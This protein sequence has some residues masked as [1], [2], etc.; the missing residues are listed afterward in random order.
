MSEARKKRDEL[1]GDIARGINPAQAIKEKKAVSEGKY[2]FEN[3][4]KDYI[5][6]FSSR[7]TKGHA[8]L[9]Y[10]RLELNVFP[11]LGKQ[12]I[13]TITAPE[14]LE[15]LRKIEKRGALETAQRVR[16]IC[17]SVFRYAIAT[18]LAERDPA[19][20]LKGALTPPPKRHYA[21]ITEPK[22][23]AKL[24]QDMEK[25]EASYVVYCALQ[26]TPHLFVRPG[27]L[28]H[29]E[30]SEIDFEAKE[31]R[32]PAEKMKMKTTHIVPLSK[33]VFAMLKELHKYTGEGKYLF[34]AITSR[35]RP[36]SENTIN[37]ALRR[38]GYTKDDMT[39]H[40]FRSLASTLLNEQGWNRDA[41]ERQLAHGERNKVRAAYNYAEFMPERR[42]MMQWWS[43]YLDELRSG[44]KTERRGRKRK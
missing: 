3:V 37:V 7:W 20:D 8:E 24:L 25:C 39:A 33:Q 43:D 5:E 15:V 23:V 35:L 16:G 31:W 10:R 34:P 36:M 41:I 13:S 28:R 4:A 29:A 17:S 12:A 38:I 9:V 27:E 6:K 1:R 2:H 21:S 11:F 14:L 26:I 30:W 42:K 44:V 32:I 18:G 40:G 19:A 22:K